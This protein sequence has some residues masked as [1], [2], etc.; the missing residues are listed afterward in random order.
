VHARIP[1][2]TVEE[3]RSLQ[4]ENTEANDRFG[5]GLQEMPPVGRICGGS[6]RAAATI[7]KKGG[8]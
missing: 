6:R 3:V 1:T 2:A 4:L 8:G 7:V 5:S